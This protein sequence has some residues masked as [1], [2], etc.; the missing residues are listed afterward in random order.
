[1]AVGDAGR[2][3]HRDAPGADT[4][5]ELVAQPALPHPGLTDDTDDLGVALHRPWPRRLREQRV[6]GPARP[7]GD[8]RRPS[9]AAGA[10]KR[11]PEHV[12]AQRSPRPLHRPWCRGPRAGTS[13]PTS[14]AVCSVRYALPGSAMRLH[15]LRQPHGVPQRGRIQR[16]VVADPADHHLPG[17]QPQPHVQLDTLRRGAARPST[18]RSP[19]SDARRHG[20]R[21]GHGPPAPPA[22]RTGP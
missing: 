2:P 9:G 21:A 12:D 22:P 19:S 5:G 15:P 14:R 6:P 11:W 1:M 16:H 7:A 13:P 17:V 10:D 4:L 20:R 8:S 3:P 18:R